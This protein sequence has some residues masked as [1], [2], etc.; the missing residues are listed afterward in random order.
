MY[1]G[2]RFATFLCSACNCLYGSSTTH[3]YLCSTRNGGDGEEK[4]VED[5]VNKK[6]EKMYAFFARY[7]YKRRSII[8]STNAGKPFY[9]A[10]VD[11][12]SNPESKEGSKGRAKDEERERERER[13]REGER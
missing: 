10:R 6:C 3:V 8:F 5:E 13:E 7:V 12:E 11:H 1:P 2:S 4:Y 9:C